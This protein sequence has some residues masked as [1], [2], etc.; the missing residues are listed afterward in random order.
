MAKNKK[1]RRRYR[2]RW[3]HRPLPKE[4][5]NDIIRMFVDVQLAMELKLHMGK[6]S[7]SEIDSAIELFNLAGLSVVHRD[8]ELEKGMED[9]FNAGVE[10]LAAVR[11]RGLSL[12]PVRFVCTASERNAILDAL[13]VV[14]QYL[15][16]ETE[17]D[18]SRLLLEWTA[19][20]ILEEHDGTTDTTKKA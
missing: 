8:S 11:K 20:H 14:G 17:A 10:A 1:P 12:S 5:A 6:C 9:L 3:V 4:Q 13:E 18:A 19:L 2:R 16:D 7:L 15:I